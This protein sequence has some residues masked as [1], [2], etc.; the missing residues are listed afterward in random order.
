MALA[1]TPPTLFGEMFHPNDALGVWGL[2]AWLWRDNPDET[3]MG[4]NPNVAPCPS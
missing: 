3:F 1:A 2:H 4:W